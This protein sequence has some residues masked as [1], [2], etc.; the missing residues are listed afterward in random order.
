M[1]WGMH[2]EIFKDIFVHLCKQTF[3]IVIGQKSL[4]TIRVTESRSSPWLNFGKFYLVTKI[5]IQVLH[6]Q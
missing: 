6:W 3:C 1:K 5:R 4:V 2:N